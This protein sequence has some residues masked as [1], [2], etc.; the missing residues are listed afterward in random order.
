MKR[1]VFMGSPRYAVSILD[2][3]QKHEGFDVVALVTQ[4]DKISGKRQNLQPPQIKKFVIENSLEIPILQ[5]DIME[6]PLFLEA[7]KDLNPDFIVVAAYGQILP[8]TLYSLCPSINLHASLLPRYRGSSPLQQEIIHA[9]HWNGI[10][11]HQITDKVD[12][13]SVLGYAVTKIEPDNNVL[14]LREIYASMAA[15]LVIKVIENYEGLNPVPQKDCDSSYYRKISKE[16]ARVDFGDAQMLYASFK[17]YY[18]WP[19]VR[20]YNGIKLT[21]MELEST[22]GAFRQGE[23]LEIDSQSSS[24]VIGCGKGKVRLY[25]IKVPNH[26]EAD[27]EGYL[28][29][30]GLKEGDLFE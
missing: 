15:R 30:K 13:G 20:L 24:A 14:Q 19:E 12:G 3:L 17:A 21:D 26:H 23:I 9:E 29:G 10:T 25:H 28:A 11:A 6:N 18:G 22:D 5:P 8:V 2:S 4:P 1:I 7:L 27:V 16:D